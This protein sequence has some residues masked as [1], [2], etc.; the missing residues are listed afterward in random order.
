MHTEVASSPLANFI[1]SVISF[2]STIAAVQLA[3]QKPSTLISKILTTQR[4]LE[5]NKS[6]LANTQ[7]PRKGL[8]NINFPGSEES[9][10]KASRETEN[11]IV[12]GEADV[13]RLGKELRYTQ[14]VVV[15]EL[16]GWTTWREEW[17]REEIKK[18]AKAMV[19]KEKERLRGMQRA[20]RAL[21]EA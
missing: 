12:Q 11:K 13:Q 9:R 20:V 8:M 4:T 16:A 17:G 14:E 7:Y 18:L 10:V 5:K 3:L 21:K 19:V 6:N 2:H 1:S 15:G